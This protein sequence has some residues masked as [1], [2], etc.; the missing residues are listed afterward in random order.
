MAQGKQ[1]QWLQQLKV[2]SL[3]FNVAERE[4]RNTEPETTE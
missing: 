4:T 1:W 2:A 3:M